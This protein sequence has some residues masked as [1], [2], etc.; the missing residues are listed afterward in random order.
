MSRIRSREDLRKLRDFAKTRRNMG[1]LWGE[2]GRG[3]LPP[4]P[5]AFAG[6][7][8][9]SMIVPPARVQSPECITIGAGVMIHEHAWL[10]VV[11]QPG[12]PP[13]RL[14]IG[15]GTSINRFIKIVCAG[16]VVIEQDVLIGDHVFIADAHYRHD[17]PSVPILKQPLAEPRP[18]RIGRGT[19]LG[20]RALISPG[21]TLGENAYVGAAAVV[22]SDVPARTIVVG[23]P[24]RAVRRYDPETREWVPVERG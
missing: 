10:C 8:A 14:V 7:G 1:R 2:V 18:V 9:G 21:V 22:S 23:D 3:L 12:L 19:H 16:E 11:P 13:P 17:D 24:A 6:F 4:P 15:D 20:F 5:R